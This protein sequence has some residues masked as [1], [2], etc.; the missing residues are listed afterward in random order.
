MKITKRWLEDKDACY[1]GVK[2]YEE[3]N[4]TLIEHTEL[5]NML[6]DEGESCWTFWLI[7][8]LL[9]S[10]RNTMWA[11]NSARLVL[12]IFEAENPDDNSARK[13]IECAENPESTHEELYAA[14]GAVE[15]KTKEAYRYYSGI[16]IRSAALSA[17]ESGLRYAAIS[18]AMYAAIAAGSDSDIERKIIDS[19]L[20]IIKEQGDEKNLR[21]L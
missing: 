6:V 16:A 21:F 8:E 7:S 1:E 18:A 17:V 4:L 19:G 10:S 15:A 5:V 11:C 12:P 2:W 20:K 14:I 3:N 13:C 9:A